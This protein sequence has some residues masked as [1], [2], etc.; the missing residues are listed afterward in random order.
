MDLIPVIDIEIGNINI[1]VQNPELDQT[2]IKSKASGDIPVTKWHHDSYPFVCVV[3][4]SD[5]SGMVGG[6][7]AVKTGGG[8][9]IKV[10]GPQ[11]V[12]LMP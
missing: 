10:R 4:M 2:D 7:T 5:A 3:M 9:V 12:S 11:I 1:S 8:E 6:E